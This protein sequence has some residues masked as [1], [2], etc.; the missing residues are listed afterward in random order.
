[1]GLNWVSLQLVR[2]YARRRV[3]SFGYPSIILPREHCEEV[4]GFMPEKFVAPPKEVKRYTELPDARCIFEKWN[5]ELT[6]VD[7][8]KHEG[9]EI[10]AD[11]NYPQDF[12]EFDFVLDAGTIEHVCNIGEA[13]KTMAMSVAPG[14]RILHTPPMTM[15]NH[16]FYNLNPTLFFHFYEENGFEL[17][18][19]HARDDCGAGE[20]YQVSHHGRFSLP[21]NCAMYVIAKRMDRR[22]LAWPIQGRYLK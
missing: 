7:A 22:P 17:R 3:L 9:S 15:L 5:L 12:G 18:H 2:D 14:G 1:M 11:L 20:E 8:L 6:V 4:L 10:I 16:G 21:T 19:M 13:L